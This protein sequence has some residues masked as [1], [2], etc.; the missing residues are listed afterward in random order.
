MDFGL[1]C[2]NAADKRIPEYADIILELNMLRIS[3]CISKRAA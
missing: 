1:T 3:Q 2:L